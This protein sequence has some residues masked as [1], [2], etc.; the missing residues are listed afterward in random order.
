MELLATIGAKIGLTASSAAAAGTTVASTAIP[1]AVYLTGGTTAAASTGLSL[2]GLASGIS[3]ASGALSLFSGDG[4][5]DAIA[6]QTRN[7]TR[8]LELQSK[9]ER[10][11]AK[12]EE[13]AAKE[14]GNAVLDNLRRT[15]ASQQLAFSANGVDGD[16]G[17]GSAIAENT[18]DAAGR[19]IGLTRDDALMRI[20]SRR[21][22]AS[23]LMRE[24]GMVSAAGAEGALEARRG[25]AISAIS[26]LSD[27][28]ERRVRRG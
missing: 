26:G 27:T 11:A 18:I 28:I 15:L 16:F 20:S 22:R 14:S 1:G 4:Q 2:S 21:R 24:R 7:R 25:G 23:E 8:A 10:L 17:S 19:D 6:D 12:Q 3:L 5:A 13:L 9:D